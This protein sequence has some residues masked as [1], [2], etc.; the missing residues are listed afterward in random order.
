MADADKERSEAR[1]ILEKFALKLGKVKTFE[2]LG[3]ASDDSG[4]REEHDGEKCKVDFRTIML[5]NAPKSDEECLIV[6]KGAWV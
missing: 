3:V 4:V 5:K 2:S 1:A 6:E